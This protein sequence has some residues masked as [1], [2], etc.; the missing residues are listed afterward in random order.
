MKEIGLVQGSEAQAKPLIINGD[1]VYVHKDI[2]KV[3]REDMH[4][5]I[6][7][8]YEYY[9][10]LYTRDEYLQVIT[11]QNEEMMLAIAE[12]GTLVAGETNG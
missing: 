11:Q 3:E 5:N 4:G 9:E 8:F 2:K 10:Y 1:I 6:I 7:T 12:L